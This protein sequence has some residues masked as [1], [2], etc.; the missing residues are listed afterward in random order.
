MRK[1]LQALG[2]RALSLA[3][4][5]TSLNFARGFAADSENLKKTPLYDFHV[6]N[7]G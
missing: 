1:A 7:G 3:E 4:N 6:A 5:P 2:S